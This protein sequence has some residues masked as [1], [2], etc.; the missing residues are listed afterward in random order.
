MRKRTLTVT[1]FIV[2]SLITV[3]LSAQMRDRGRGMHRGD[4]YQHYHGMCYGDPQHMRVNLKLTDKQIE[5]IG[6]INLK[7]RNILIEYRERLVPKRDMLRK[8]LLSEKIN[9]NDVRTILREISDIEIEM[10]LIKIKHRLE[11]E[12]V[13]TKTQ[14]D[15]LRKER[16]LN[17]N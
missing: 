8:F 12:K 5:Q 6:K 1:L 13:L 9:F 2:I 11:I 7:Y 10:R 4:G 15:R 14:R 16:T 3:E 17:W